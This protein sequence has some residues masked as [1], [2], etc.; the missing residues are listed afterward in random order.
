MY[1]QLLLDLLQAGK[2]RLARK[3]IRL[4]FGISCLF[5]QM[6]LFANGCL[7]SDGSEGRRDVDG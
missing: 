3:C 1:Q 6:L 7:V 2:N 5:L 4:A